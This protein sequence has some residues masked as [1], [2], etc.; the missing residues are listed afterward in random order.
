MRASELA[1]ANGQERQLSA[2]HS[3]CCLIVQARWQYCQGS[4]S[5]SSIAAY[6]C[7]WAFP[8]GTASA[9]AD[10]RRQRRCLWLGGEV[11]YM[12]GCQMGVA[13]EFYFCV[14]VY[15]THLL[16]ASNYRKQNQLI[17]MDTFPTDADM[18]GLLAFSYFY[19]F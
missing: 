1:R 5:L 15:L 12:A 8:I 10:C 14:F 18:F 7:W 17:L 4:P 2:T 11:F 9:T 13:W 6:A 16:S 3:R 19:P